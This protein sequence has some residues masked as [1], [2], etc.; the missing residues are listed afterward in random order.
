M[1]LTLELAQLASQIRSCQKCS[2][3]GNPCVLWRG[4]VRADIMVIGEAPGLVEAQQGL[5]WVGPAGKLLDKAATAAGLDTNRDC[6]ITNIVKCRPTSS[7]PGR[8]NDT[9]T[10][11]IIGACKPWLLQEIEILR[12]RAIVCMGKS[13]AIGIEGI[14]ASVPMRA[15]AQET[16]TFFLGDKTEIPLFVTYHTAAILHMAGGQSTR[17][18]KQAILNTLRRAKAVEGLR[19]QGA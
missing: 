7:T 12:P 2:L 11:E 15:A 6:F 1:D 14:K 10:R 13:A 18:M 19:V 3:A 16:Y 17:D 4:S 9:P 5:P 8:Q